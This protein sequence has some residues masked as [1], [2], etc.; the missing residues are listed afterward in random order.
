MIAS[1]R[2]G[3]FRD[4]MVPQIVEAQTGERAFHI[5]NIGAAFGLAALLARIL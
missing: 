2:L 4:G 5:A 1:L 3:Q